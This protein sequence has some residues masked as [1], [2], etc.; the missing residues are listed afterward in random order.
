MMLPYK[1]PALQRKRWLIGGAALALLGVALVTLPLG[2]PLAM[3]SYDLPFL[4]RSPIANT[5]IVVVVEDAASLE[6]LGQK[7]W[8]P[9]RTLHAKLLERLHE[10]GAGLV[11]FDISFGTEKPED[12]VFAAAIRLH[13]NVI[14]G[15]VPKKSTFQTMDQP[16]ARLVEFNPPSKLEAASA[17]WGLLLIGDLDSSFRVRKMLTEWEGHDTAIWLAAKQSGKIP[18]GEKSKDER[19]INFYG[20][21]PAL[22]RVSLSQ[23]LGVGDQRLS[24][25][26]LRGK[27]VFVGSAPSIIS[28]S[29]QRDVIATPYTRFGHDFTPGVEV[30]ANAYAN[31]VSKDWLH[32]LGTPLQCLLTIIFTAGAIGAFVWLGRSWSIPVALILLIALFGLTLFL[33][34]SLGWWWNWLVPA[35][36]QLPLA[37]LLVFFCPRLPMVAFI[38]YRRQGGDK[39]ALAVLHGLWTRGFDAFLDVKDISSGEWL[40]QLLK[41]IER[42]PNFILILSPNLLAEKK[43]GDADWVREE[44]LHALARGKKIVPIQLEDFSYPTVLPK[45]MAELPAQQVIMHHHDQPNATFDKLE[46]FLRKKKKRTH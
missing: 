36:I 18:V 8:P 32:R 37:M 17:G 11:V 22:N 15:S 43:D 19:W 42:S 31:L 21:P 12:D 25:D 44:I 46:E 13:R 2:D 1:G 29:G 30:S 34:W 10:G 6:A 24:P 35:V 20:A 38:S 14:L 5:N 9:P 39:F 16:G 23:V 4:F 7:S 3:L 45:E 28:A 40:P 41:G 27:V 33:Q 26:F